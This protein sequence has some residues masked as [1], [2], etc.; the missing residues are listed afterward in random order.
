MN[1]ITFRSRPIELEQLTDT[2]KAFI[3]NPEGRA[4]YAERPAKAIVSLRNERGTEYKTYLAT[5]NALKQAY[6]EL[7]EESALREYGKPYEELEFA[8]KKRIRKEIPLVIS[9]AETGL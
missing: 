6:D 4:D 5:Y 9:E 1:T 7:W 8:Q 3:A 2:I